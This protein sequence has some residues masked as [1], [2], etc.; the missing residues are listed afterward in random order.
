MHLA[1]T[2]NFDP[3]LTYVIKYS[4][5]PFTFSKTL[6]TGSKNR[7]PTEYILEDGSDKF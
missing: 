4:A 7:P 3:I 2:N 1:F 5:L 6:I